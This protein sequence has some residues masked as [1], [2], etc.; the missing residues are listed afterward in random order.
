M[1]NKVCVVGGS[2]FYCAKLSQVKLLLCFFG[3]RS[4]ENDCCDTRIII[5]AIMMII[6]CV[7]VFPMAFMK[8]TIEESEQHTKS[9]VNAIC[10]VFIVLLHISFFFLDADFSHSGVRRKQETN[11]RGER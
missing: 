4:T 1:H 5:I 2:Y 3:S 7:F 11:I 10:D 9:Q 6:L 8:M